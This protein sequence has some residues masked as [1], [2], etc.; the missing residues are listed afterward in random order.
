V[1][2]LNS[3]FPVHLDL[4][5]GLFGH[6]FNLFLF[7]FLPLGLF[8]GFLALVT[9]LSLAPLARLC[10][11]LW[12]DSIS[13]SVLRASKQLRG[14]YTHSA[15]AAARFAVPAPSLARTRSDTEGGSIGI[16]DMPVLGEQVK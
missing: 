6:C 1:F 4:E 3:K 12:V 15:G 5:H 7:L 9:L 14:G 8:L 13:T 16:L 10:D 11:W 2:L